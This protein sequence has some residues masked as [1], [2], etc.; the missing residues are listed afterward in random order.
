MANLSL[1]LFCMSLIYCLFCQSIVISCQCVHWLFSVSL[2]FRQHVQNDN[3]RHRYPT[4][5]VLCQCVHW[6][7]RCVSIVRSVCL[8]LI[9][10]VIASYCVFVTVLIFS[11]AL[12]VLLFLLSF[13]CI[14]RNPF[15]LRFHMR[16]FS[17]NDTRPKVLCTPPVA[18]WP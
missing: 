15:S 12:W 2:F 13:H 18:H 8:S 17:Q 9:L 14:P 11:S 4:S 5:V 6:L 1:L 3:H 16:I 10:Y 7:F